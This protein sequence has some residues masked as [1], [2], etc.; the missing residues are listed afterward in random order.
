MKKTFRIDCLPE[1]ALQC[2]EGFAVVAVDVI[3]ATTM[4]VT[5]ASLGWDC[6]PVGSLR[7]AWELA[8][9]SDNPLLAGEINGVEP[10]GFNMTNSPARLAAMKVSSGPLILLSS[11]GTRLIANACGCDVLYLSCFRNA[12]STAHR[13]IR[14]GHER[15]ALLGAGSRG[16]FREEDQI[17]CAWIAARLMRTGYAPENQDTARV[18][19]LWANAKAA[20]CL[21]SK[22]VDYLRRTSQLGDLEFIL[23]HINDLDDTFV[24]EKGDPVACYT[25]N[26]PLRREVRQV[27][28]GWGAQS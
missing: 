23:D 5:A 6:Y 18:A 3:R 20:D 10:E 9:Q 8:H 12:A 27:A 22:S 4:A 19:H 24:V 28:A 25:A 15:I 26:E 1:S 16:E 14:E 17:G 11:S 21:V 7:A 2:R 13:L